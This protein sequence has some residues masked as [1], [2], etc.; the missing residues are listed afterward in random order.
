M[1][2]EKYLDVFR[3]FLEISVEARLGDTENGED[4]GKQ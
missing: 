4:I 3:S 2:L 1:R